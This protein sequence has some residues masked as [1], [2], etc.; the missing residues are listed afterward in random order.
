MKQIQGKSFFVWVSEGSS[1]RESIT[2]M[3]LF[4][5]LLRKLRPKKL[6]T[7]IWRKVVGKSASNNPER[8][9]EWFW[10]NSWSKKFE[11]MAREIIDGMFAS[12]KGK[13]QEWVRQLQ[14][15]EQFIDHIP[16][17]LSG[18]SRAHFPDNLS[19]NSWVARDVTK[20]QTKKL[21][22]LL[23]FYFH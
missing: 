21:S 4:V 1:Y 13:Q 19:R 9:C 7:A 14:C 11:R 12:A 5:A 23:S 15:Q 3:F 10:V 17:Y 2:A 8:Y 16:Y 22:I 6:D 18:L 20:N